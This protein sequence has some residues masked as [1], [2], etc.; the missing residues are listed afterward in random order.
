VL[1]SLL[2]C[3]LVLVTAVRPSC[4]M[5]LLLLGCGPL[6]LR[7]CGVA[8]HQA[9]PLRQRWGGQLQKMAWIQT[10]AGGYA[11][12]RLKML[13]CLLLASS[14]DLPFTML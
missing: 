5:L 8:V 11:S 14:P 13:L 2:V 3:L 12:I 1:G 4:C 7:K 6:A 9:Q 10:A